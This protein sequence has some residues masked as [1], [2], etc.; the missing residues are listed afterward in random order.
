MTFDA[1]C[2]PVKIGTLFW[3][4]ASKHKDIPFATMRTHCFCSIKVLKYNF[5][6]SFLDVPGISSQNAVKLPNCVFN[7]EQVF[8][9]E[10]P[11]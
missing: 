4:L 2:L 6:A 3:T 9:S 8:N 11:N 5:V 1:V 10:A 7:R